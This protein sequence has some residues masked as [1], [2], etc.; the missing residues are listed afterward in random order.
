VRTKTF[1]YSH[2]NKVSIMFWREILIKLKL[3]NL[4][5]IL[6]ETDEKLTVKILKKIKRYREI[7][8]PSLYCQISTTID[9]TPNHPGQMENE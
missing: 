5:Y 9:F 6:I 3:T 8:Y 1:Y 7:L 2:P 4:E